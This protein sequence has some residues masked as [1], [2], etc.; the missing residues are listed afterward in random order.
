LRNALFGL[1]RH[2]PTS[3]RCAAIEPDAHGARRDRST[4]QR[5]A[6]IRRCRRRIAAPLRHR[7]NVKH[8]L[9]DLA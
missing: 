5:R 1:A 8:T 7:R 4:R 2:V 9:V 3:R 6:R